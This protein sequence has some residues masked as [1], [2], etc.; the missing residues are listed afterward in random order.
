MWVSERMLKCTSYINQKWSVYD[1]EW[2]ILWIM[3]RWIQMLFASSNRWHHSGSANLLNN[4]NG[5][6]TGSP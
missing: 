6:N 5:P 4:N 2:V 3:G 1:T